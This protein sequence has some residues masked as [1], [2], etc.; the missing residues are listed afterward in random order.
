[1]VSVWYSG[2]VGGEVNL[3]MDMVVRGGEWM[4]IGGKE[5]DLIYYVGMVVIVID[6]DNVKLY[7]NRLL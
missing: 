7:C 5:R 4:V 6:I 2:C 3:V 1:M